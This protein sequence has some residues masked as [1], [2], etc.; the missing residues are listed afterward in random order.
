MVGADGSSNCEWKAGWNKNDVGW[1]YSP[2]PINKYYYTFKNDWK[3]IDGEWYIFD[4][5]G[6]ALQDVWYFDE[7]DKAW[8]TIIREI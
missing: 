2:D 5:N 1:W 7:S 4:D 8:Y 6:Y 3:E